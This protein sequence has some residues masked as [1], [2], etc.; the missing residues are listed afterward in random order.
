MDSKPHHRR[1]RSKMQT[2]GNSSNTRVSLT[3]RLPW[4]ESSGTD[5]ITVCGWLKTRKRNYEP[6]SEIWTQAV[7]PRLRPSYSWFLGVKMVLWFYFFKSPSL[8]EVHA[9]ILGDGMIP[10]ICLKVIRG[11]GIQM[12]HEELELVTGETSR[13]VRRSSWY[14]VSHDKW[15]R[16][17][18]KEKKS[19]YNLFW[20]KLSS[21]S[22][23]WGE[24]FFVV[25][26]S[27]GERWQLLSFRQL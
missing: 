20:E 5:P 8:F 6:I 9:E 22:Q 21:N 11:R 25:L 16:F 17:P 4:K 23:E 24:L 1:A 10:W 18:F 26:D 15:I 12:S 27:C 13:W 3:D 19:R 7:S 2:V 14:W